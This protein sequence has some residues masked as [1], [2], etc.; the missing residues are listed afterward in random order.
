LS[1]FLPGGFHSEEKER[2]EKETSV[3]KV[4]VFARKKIDLNEQMLSNWSIGQQEC[5]VNGVKDTDK[6][7]SQLCV[8]GTIGKFDGRSHQFLL[9]FCLLSLFFWL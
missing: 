9:N 5:V 8:T 2:T 1:V 6:G 7:V 3:F 4:C